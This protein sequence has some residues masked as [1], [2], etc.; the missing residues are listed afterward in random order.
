[1]GQGAYYYSLL[2][3]HYSLLTTHYSLLTTHYSL[4]TTH[5]S[6]PSP[7]ATH[8]SLLTTC[9]SLLTTHC[10]PLTT[11]YSLLTTHYLLL[12]TH[13]SLLTTHYLLLQFVAILTL[14]GYL[15]YLRW[16]V[17]KTAAESDRAMLTTGDFSVLLRELN[18]GM[19]PSAPVRLTPD[20]LQQNLYDDLA[21]LG[22]GRDRI[23]QL[24]VSLLLTTYYLLLTTHYSLLTTNY[25]L[26]TTHYLLLTTYY[27][28]L[29][30]YYLL[31]TT[32]YLLLLVV[33]LVPPTTYY[34]LQGVDP[35]SFTYRECLTSSS[36]ILGRHPSPPHPTPL[37][38]PL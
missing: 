6:H 34:L 23:A 9:Y 16:L 38:L 37:L 29:T 11:H 32:Y 2:T 22:F 24:E 36:G 10:S 4:L 7:L 30:T 33:L 20:E 12:I 26:L 8:Y 14:L 15:V 21:E 19:D 13:Y 18:D 1:M 25:L 31:L 35:G 17:R 3:T 28:R 27:L 5:H